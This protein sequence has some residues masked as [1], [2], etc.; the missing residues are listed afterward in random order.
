[1][2][3]EKSGFNITVSCT[4]DASIIFKCRAKK[5]PGVK[6]GDKIDVT[7]DQ[8]SGA[9]EFEP[10][11][12]AEVTDGQITVPDDPELESR[13]LAILG[14]KGTITFTGKTTGVKVQYANAWFAS[15]TPEQ[16]G[17]DAAL[18]TAVITIQ[19]VGA[20]PA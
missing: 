7:T 18:P 14:K 4:Q 5:R 11:C 6:L 16:S 10:A 17:I 19:S 12:L 3:A 9:K 20:F 13:I 2:A 15:Y 8:S 1:M